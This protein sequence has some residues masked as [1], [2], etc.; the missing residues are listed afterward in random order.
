MDIRRSASAAAAANS[1]FYA[2]QQP[3]RTSSRYAHRWSNRADPPKNRVIRRVTRTATA[4]RT[5]SQGSPPR[6]LGQLRN[7]HTKCLAGLTASPH[8]QPCSSLAT[9]RHVRSS[10][11]SVSPAGQDCSHTTSCELLVIDQWRVYLPCCDKECDISGDGGG[12]VHGC[13]RG[14]GRDYG[15]RGR[16]GR[17]HDDRDHGRRRHYEQHH[18]LRGPRA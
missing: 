5:C 14:R 18:R 11:V 6:P 9:Y 10:S 12:D 8:L 1:I 2:A 15:V 13:E 17:V 3:G 4:Q 16:D 7:T